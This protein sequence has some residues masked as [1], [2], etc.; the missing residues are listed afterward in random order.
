M[1][2]G[3]RSPIDAGHK[4]LR[5]DSYQHRIIGGNSKYHHRMISKLRRRV[6]LR[7]VRDYEK[8]SGRPLEDFSPGESDSH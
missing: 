6:A 4:Y 1:R 5:S 8:D 7:E 3:K 2:G